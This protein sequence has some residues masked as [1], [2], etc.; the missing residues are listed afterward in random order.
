[1]IRKRGE[2]VLVGV[3]WVRRTDIYAHEILCRVFY[4]F[5]DMRSGW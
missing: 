5:V 1:M 2:V 4:D 3:P